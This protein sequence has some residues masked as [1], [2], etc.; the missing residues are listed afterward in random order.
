MSRESSTDHAIRF[1]ASAIGSG[2]A[3]ISTLPTDVVKVRL[4]IQHGS[5]ASQKYHGFIDCGYKIATEESVF[6]L[7]K[8]LAP[9]LIRQVSYSALSLLIYEPVRNFISQMRSSKPDEMKGT[10][11]VERI[12]AGGIAGVLSIICFN[13]T[14]VLKTQMQMSTESKSMGTVFRHILKTDG[15]PG[16]FAGIQPNII[17]TFLVNA[18]QLGVYDQIKTEIFEPFF[19]KDSTFAHLG[20]SSIAGIAT[21]ITSTPA[22]VVKTRLMSEA[23]WSTPGNVEQRAAFG[24]SQGYKPYTGMVDAA[25]RITREEGVAALYK[26]FVPI[27]LR[28]TIWCTVFFMTYEQLRIGF[29]IK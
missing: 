26:G 24:V 12:S 9:A 3:E 27:C 18:T 17:R 21:A 22:D 29:H 4:Q 23:G 28:R 6:A 2:L 20:A 5:P 19:G 14:E 7:W 1:V 8:G 25:V 11:F 13:W 16:F 15:I 10:S